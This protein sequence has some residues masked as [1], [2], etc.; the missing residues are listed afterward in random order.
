MHMDIPLN[1]TFNFIVGD[2]VRH[3]HDSIRFDK[4]I[5]GT[6]LERRLNDLVVETINKGMC[7]CLHAYRDNC[8]RLCVMLPIMIIFEIQ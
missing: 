5:D 4:Q 1:Y 2:R 3:T 7:I 6:S 8:N